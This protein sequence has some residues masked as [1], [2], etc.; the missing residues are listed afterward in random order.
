MAMKRNFLL[1]FYLFSISI[2]YLT[3]CA[4]TG[5]SIAAFAISPSTVNGLASTGLI[6]CVYQMNKFVSSEV[7][8]LIG[9]QFH[10]RVKAKYPKLFLKMEK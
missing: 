6:Y 1:F 8:R 3:I 4:C 10:D 5:I 7:D 2:Y 9:K